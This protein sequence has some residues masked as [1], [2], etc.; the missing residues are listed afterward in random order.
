[1][2]TKTIKLDEDTYHQL[3]QL[4]GKR[5]TFSETVKRLV[6]IRDGLCALWAA[7]GNYREYAEYEERKEA[8]SHGRQ[9]G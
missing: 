4:R 6:D 2:A 1:M 7:R 5:E 3:D 9:T 8:A